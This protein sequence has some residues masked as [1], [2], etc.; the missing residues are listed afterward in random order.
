MKSLDAVDQAI[1]KERMLGREQIA[2]PRIGDFI[3]F[4]SGEIERFSHYLDDSL[5]TSPIKSGSV[6]L[7]G[8]GNGNF[9]GGFNPAIPL[10]SLTLSNE[11]M[12]GAFWFFHHGVTGPGR[13]VYFSIPC[14]VYVT[15]AIYK[16]FIR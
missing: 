5:Q 4:P 9:S 3:R 8:S 13:G 6:Y 12:E 1:L 7:L 16:G 15:T 2:Q 10:D 14:R 11:L